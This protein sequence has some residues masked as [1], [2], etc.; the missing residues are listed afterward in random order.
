[1]ETSTLDMSFESAN[2]LSS[3]SSP[4]YWFDIFL[5]ASNFSPGGIHSILKFLLSSVLLIKDTENFL[6]SEVIVYFFNFVARA[7]S[8]QRNHFVGSSRRF[9]SRQ[10]QKEGEGKSQSV[11]DN[12]GENI[13]EAAIKIWV[14]R[15]AS[16]AVWTMVL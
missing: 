14:V 16:T 11:A 3:T 6:E 12:A 10:V 5:T 8:A 15:P 7:S 13:K 4:K 9:A 1:M 2:L